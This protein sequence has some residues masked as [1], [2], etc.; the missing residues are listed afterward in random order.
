M[1]QTTNAFRLNR[2][3]NEDLVFVQLCRVCLP[4]TLANTTASVLEGVGPE[5]GFTI[6][7]AREIGGDGK[8][9]MGPYGIAIVDA[10]TST[11]VA[12]K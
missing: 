7:I 12:G 2:R 11:D 5:P 4:M 3:R 1:N 9:T 8:L 6:P 10:G